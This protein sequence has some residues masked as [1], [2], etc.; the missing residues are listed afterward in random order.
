MYTGVLY[1]IVGLLV[2]FSVL[3]Y[4]VVQILRARGKSQMKDRMRRDLDTLD[5]L[6]MPTQAN[7]APS[8]SEQTNNFPQ[9]PI[10][11]DDSFTPSHLT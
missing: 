5:Q 4:L 8:L 7:P 6:S 3:L 2:V 10:D 11:S 9:V 1:G